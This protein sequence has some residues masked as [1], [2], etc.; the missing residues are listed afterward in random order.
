MPGQQNEAPEGPLIEYLRLLADPPN[1]SRFLDVRWRRPGGRMRRRFI[2]TTSPERAAALLLGRSAASDVYVG[3]AARDGDRDG[4]RAAISGIG[5][6]YVESDS[7]S[8]AARLATFGCPPSVVIAS[9]TPGHHQIYWRLTARSPPSAVEHTNRRLA[10]ALAGDPACADAARILRPPQTLNHKH[11]AP[12]PVTLLVFR[13]EL[14][15]TLAQ[16]T[17]GLPDLPHPPLRPT[18]DRPSRTGRTRL[19]RELLAIPTADYVRVLAGLTPNREGKVRCPFHD[20][21]DPSLQLYPD[22]G[23]YCFGSGCGA[24]GSIFDFAARLWEVTPRGVAFLR[25][26]ERLADRFGL[27]TEYPRTPA[28]HRAAGVERRGR[29]ARTP[30]HF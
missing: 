9:G 11:A 24:G 4:G 8:T 16:L 23:F 25:L 15:Y 30:S 3:V 17:A 10:L 27:A 19:D 26:R 22:G 20:D 1:P 29:A 6:A 18:S 21:H 12:L 14:R 2:P 7:A 28:A 5:L 13:P